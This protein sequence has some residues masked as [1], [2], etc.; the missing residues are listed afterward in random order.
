[1]LDQ[2]FENDIRQI[3]GFCPSKEQ[4]RQTVMCK[5]CFSFDCLSLTLPLRS[6][7]HMAR[8]RSSSREHLPAQ[9][10]AHHCRQRRADSQ[11]ED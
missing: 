7:R 6:L 1:M 3:I 9:A 8:I 10:C 11:Q 2:G 4:G 5:F